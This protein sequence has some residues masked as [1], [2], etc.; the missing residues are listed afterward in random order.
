VT[1]GEIYDKYDA[2]FRGIFLVSAQS[3][4]GIDELFRAAAIKAVRF[5]QTA[6]PLDESVVLPEMP[7]TLKTAKSGCC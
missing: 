2:D 3:G 4:H 1:C 5:I 7:R 6:N